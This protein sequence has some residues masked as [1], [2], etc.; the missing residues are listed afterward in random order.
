MKRY[1]NR[2]ILLGLGVPGLILAS[3]AIYWFF[4]REQPTIEEEDRR[5]RR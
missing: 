4:I 3:F 2:T 5:R 1:R